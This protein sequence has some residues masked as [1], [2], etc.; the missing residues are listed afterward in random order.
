MDA[1]Y[2]RKTEESDF[3]KAKKKKKKQQ[4]NSDNCLRDLAVVLKRL[5]KNAATTITSDLL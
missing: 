3:A 5:P 4:Q 2:R 1:K